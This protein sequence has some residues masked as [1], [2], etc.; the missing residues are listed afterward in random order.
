MTGLGHLLRIEAHDCR[1]RAGSDRH[2]LLHEL[3]AAAD[4]TQRVGE[5][6]GA[7]RHVGRVLAE[8]M[9]GDK[10]GCE[11]ARRQ[12]PAGGD[13]D[14]ENR[15]LLILGQREPIL[16]PFEADSAQRLA[17][18]VVRLGEGL[19]ADRERL[20]QRLA[21]ADFLRSLSWKNEGDHW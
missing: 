10:R 14:G 6:E 8:T 17:Q 11:A 20:R 19:A 1:H 12:Q 4:H 3:P 5:R 18:R 7:G 9:T 15:R 2:G 13:A 16:G 21:H